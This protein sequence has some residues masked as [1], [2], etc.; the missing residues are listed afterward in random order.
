[1]LILVIGILVIIA[2][3]LLAVGLTMHSDNKSLKK[4]LSGVL[5]ALV[6]GFIPIA[7]M[8]IKDYKQDGITI[9]SNSTTKKDDDKAIQ[10]PVEDVEP[11]KETP[12]ISD[13]EVVANEVRSLYYET[14]DNKD[15]YDKKIIQDGVTAYVN[16][17]QVV[18]IEVMGDKIGET[19]SRMYYFHNNKLYFS[20]IF[21]GMLE[22]RLYFKDGILF[23][24]IDEQ[25]NAMDSGTGVENC[26][27][28]SVAREES[29]KYLQMCK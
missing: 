16:N 22:N 8:Y 4:A 23:R 28:E 21:S 13:I 9:E 26:G 3:L 14:Q 17:G 11:T 15:S 1:M 10:Q 20:F 24:Y 2:M 29:A 25:K 12:I 19:Y 27:W 18:L 6:I 7:V 5:V